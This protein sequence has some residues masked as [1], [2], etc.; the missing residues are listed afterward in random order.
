MYNAQRKLDRL[1]MERHG[2]AKELEMLQ[3]GVQEGWREVKASLT[4]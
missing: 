3:A 1:K 4:F 2:W